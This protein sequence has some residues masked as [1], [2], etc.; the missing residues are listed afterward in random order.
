[1][2]DHLPAGGVGNAEIAVQEE[3]AQ[4][5]AL[6]FGI[7]GFDVREFADDSLLVH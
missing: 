3:V 6:E 7:A 5:S 1:M 2:A 4:T